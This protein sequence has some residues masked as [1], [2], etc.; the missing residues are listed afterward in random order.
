VLNLLDKHLIPKA[1]KAEKVFYLKMKWD[2][3]QYLA[4]VVSGD[5][6]STVVDES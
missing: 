5:N 2:Y 1:S 3:F 6:R 4:E